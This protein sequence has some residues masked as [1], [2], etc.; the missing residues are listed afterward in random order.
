MLFV[1]RYLFVDADDGAINNEAAWQTANSLRVTSQAYCVIFYYYMNGPDVGKLEV[2]D[3]EAT[4]Q[5][6]TPLV[7]IVGEFL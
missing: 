4:S 3:Y 1:G 2:Y 6:L 5:Q 7:S